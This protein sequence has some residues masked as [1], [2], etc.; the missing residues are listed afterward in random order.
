MSADSASKQN[1]LKFISKICGK[2]N[3]CKSPKIIFSLSVML[4]WAGFKWWHL[5]FYDRAT[6][7]TVIIIII[8]IIEPTAATSTT[9]TNTCC[10]IQVH[11]VKAINLHFRAKRSQK[12]KYKRETA[13]KFECKKKKR[14]VEKLYNI[15]TE[16]ESSRGVPGE[17]L[18]LDVD[19]V[20][21]SPEC[22]RYQ[23]RKFTSWLCVWVSVYVCVSVLVLV[24]LKCAA[25]QLAPATTVT[26]F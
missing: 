26:R 3:F 24:S 14:I 22:K 12:A 15:E 19:V 11:F 10:S 6:P 16:V 4:W 2:S 5:R 13:G 20:A 21:K 17:R 9:T 8:I 18:P 23:S 1:W 25:V 7:K